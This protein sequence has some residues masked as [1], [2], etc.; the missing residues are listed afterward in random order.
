MKR[1]FILLLCALL[2]CAGLIPASAEDKQENEADKGKIPVLSGDTL[3]G[4]TSDGELT[5]DAEDVTEG[6]A[7]IS[8]SLSAPAGSG[9]ILSLRATFDAV[10]VTDVYLFEFDFYISDPSILWASRMMILDF[11]SSGSPDSELI[12]WYEDAFTGIDKAGWYH[13]SLP[14]DKATSR[15]FRSNHLNYFCL[16]FFQVNP[17]ADLNDVV[18]K[19]DN[20]TATKGER[21]MITMDTCD[22]AD[23][24]TDWGATPMRDEVNKQQ[25]AASLA[26]QQKIPEQPNLVSQKVYEPI[27]AQGLIYVEMDVFVSDINVFKNANYPI[28]FEITSSGTCDHQEY[29]WALDKYIKKNGW[30]R[31]SLPVVEALSCDGV[32]N[33]AAVNYLRFHTLGITQ[34]TGGVFTFRVDNITLVTIKKQDAFYGATPIVREDPNETPGTDVPGTDVP[35]TDVPGTGV[36]GTDVPGTDVPGT[37]QPPVQQPGKNE[38]D[39]RARTTAQRA[40]ILLLLMCFTIIGVD[41]VVMA[42]RRR[43]ASATS[44]VPPVEPELEE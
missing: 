22:T 30:T 7:C 15:G 1:I 41:F 25:G 37:N 31:I 39:L 40:K 12:T 19:I 34:A 32:P 14:I 36:P 2:L 29:S 16:Q 23:G 6:E 38:N 13:I 35:G 11:G 26:F 9:S 27:N 33:F 42:L 44:D 5:L 8:T 21:S 4:W 18:V 17:P 10:D 3:D 20:I 43:N 24:W 28:N